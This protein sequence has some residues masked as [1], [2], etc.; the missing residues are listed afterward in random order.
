MK[1]LLVV[2]IGYVLGVYWAVYGRGKFHF[3][4]N[5]LV[6]KFLRRVKMDGITLGARCY[7]R[8]FNLILEFPLGYEPVDLPHDSPARRW[9]RHEHQH[10]HQWRV[11]PFMAPVYIYW[12]LKSGYGH[13]PL[14]DEANRAEND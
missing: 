3:V 14:E 6:A 8:E 1:A 9:W 7:V 10:Y 12:Q 4:Y 5:G 2:L 11:R 13:N